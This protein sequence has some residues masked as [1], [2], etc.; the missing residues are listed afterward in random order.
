MCLCSL[1]ESTD[2]GPAQAERILCEPA[3]SR[4]A[5]ARNA[6][7]TAG[8][9]QTIDPVLKGVAVQSNNRLVARSDERSNPGEP[10]RVKLAAVRPQCFAAAHDHLKSS[11]EPPRIPLM[12]P[13]FAE[14]RRSRPSRGSR[15]A[16]AEVRVNLIRPER[17]PRNRKRRNQSM[18]VCTAFTPYSKDPDELL[19]EIFLIAAVASEA[20]ER[21][22]PATPM[23]TY[24]GA[25]SSFDHFQ[26][27]D[28][29]GNAEYDNVN[30]Y[31]SGTVIGP[32]PNHRSRIP[33]SFF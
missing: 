16:T 21:P 26:T 28:F 20:P 8:K 15:R 13:L 9:P 31:G 32:K 29:P 22:T 12:E 33:F 25:P 19:V 14:N 1:Q 10:V 23:P 27:V 5:V 11:I 2:G 24:L 4:A 6:P 30:C 17:R 7:Q 3:S 18:R